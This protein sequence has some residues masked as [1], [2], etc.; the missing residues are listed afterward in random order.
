MFHRALSLSIGKTKEQLEI[1][2]ALV[3]PYEKAI[4][5]LKKVV[6]YLSDKNSFAVFNPSF[7]FYTL[8]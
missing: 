2:K 4:K 3:T 1:E 7:A 5:I 6:T 8:K